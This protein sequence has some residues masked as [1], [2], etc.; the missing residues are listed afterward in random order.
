[1]RVLRVQL[2]QLGGQH[3]PDLIQHDAVEVRSAHVGDPTWVSA[4]LHGPNYFG[5]T[6][7]VKR[8]T[9]DATTWH[10][11]AVDWTPDLLVFNI[12]GHEFYRVTKAD[13]EKYGRWAF[14]NPKH[15]ITNF[16]LGGGY[17]HGVNKAETPYFG[18]PQTTVDAIKQDRASIQIDWIRVTQP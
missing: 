7:L 10:V 15:L 17:P 8:T 6:P 3:A 2:R 9:V 18:L 5:D 16:A 12:D 1:M 13:V 4:A 14:D 11:Y